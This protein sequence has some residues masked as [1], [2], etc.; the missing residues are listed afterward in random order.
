MK[1]QFNGYLK[2]DKRLFTY[3]AVS[4]VFGM[5]DIDDGYIFD[6]NDRGRLHLMPLYLVTDDI[7]VAKVINDRVKLN[8]SK[9]NHLNMIKYI[10]KINK[11]LIDSLISNTVRTIDY[12]TE[13]DQ[14]DHDGYIEKKLDQINLTLYKISNKQLK[15]RLNP[16]IIYSNYR[17]S[18]NRTLERIY[19]E[20]IQSNYDV[21]E[22]RI[23]INN[24][25][26]DALIDEYQCSALKTAMQCITG[27]AGADNIPTDF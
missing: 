20:Q 6:M 19:K 21:N 11:N 23:S 22:T 26:H 13:N 24:T 12:K 1:S 14:S 8:V 3:P 17:K 27:A 5:R 25:L 18:F 15:N 9:T 4:F 10:R 7:L 16:I 2:E